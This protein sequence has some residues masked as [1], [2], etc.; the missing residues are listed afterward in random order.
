MPDSKI[1]DLLL[2]NAKIIT[3]SNFLKEKLNNN[4]SVEMIYNPVSIKEKYIK[5]KEKSSKLI[6]GF[7][8]NFSPKKKPDL[9]VRLA[10]EILQI[11]NSEFIMMGRYNNKEYEFIINLIK[12]NNLIK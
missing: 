10:K 4:L 6:F 7:F 2:R 9:F 8:S 5:N 3:I 11:Y 1:L 12:E